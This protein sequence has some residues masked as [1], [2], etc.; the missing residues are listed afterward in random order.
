M[1]EISIKTVHKDLGVLTKIVMSMQE[2]LNDC[3]LTA[4]EEKNLEQGLKE[5]ERGET[6]SL[7]NLESEIKNAQSWTIKTFWKIL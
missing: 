6:I 3:F 1:E 2:T 4:Q 7:E 5:L